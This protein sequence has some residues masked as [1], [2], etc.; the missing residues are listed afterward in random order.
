MIPPVLQ[1]TGGKDEPN[2]VFMRTSYKRTSQHHTQNV[3][4][5]TEQ[6]LLFMKLNITCTSHHQLVILSNYIYMCILKD[7][8]FIFI[9]LCIRRILYIIT[10]ISVGFR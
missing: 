4:T 8:M 10:P 3:N 5:Q 2:I 1:T 7:D 6:K 9:L